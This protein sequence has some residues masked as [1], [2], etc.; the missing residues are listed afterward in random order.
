MKLIYKHVFKRPKLKMRG[1]SFHVLSC[2]DEVIVEHT[3]AGRRLPSPSRLDSASLTA[4]LPSSQ[5]NDGEGGGG[6][7]GS[8]AH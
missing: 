7:G 6:G 2:H 4:W 3:Y 1:K 8:L 5:I